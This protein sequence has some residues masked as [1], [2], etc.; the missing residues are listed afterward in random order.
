MSIACLKIFLSLPLL[1]SQYFQ[2]NLALSY[3]HKTK[4]FQIKVKL[5]FSFQLFGNAGTHRSPR[6]HKYQQTES[7]IIADICIASESTGSGLPLLN[8][9]LLRIIYDIGSTFFYRLTLFEFAFDRL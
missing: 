7:E 9:L 4:I 6:I 1:F 2:Q 3:N 5:F 8:R